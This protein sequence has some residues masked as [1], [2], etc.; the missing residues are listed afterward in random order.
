MRA[1]QTIQRPCDLHLLGK[2]TRS[3]T[4]VIVVALIGTES[5]RY[6]TRKHKEPLH[7]PDPIEPELLSR[8]SFRAKVV[9]H[10]YRPPHR[11]QSLKLS[12]FFCSVATQHPNLLSRQ[13]AD[14]ADSGASG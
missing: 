3:L 5:A 11:G 2:N 6:C 9:P 1:E 8:T 10:S 12:V 14:V 4:L 7:E 13:R